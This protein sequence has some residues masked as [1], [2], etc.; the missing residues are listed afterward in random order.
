MIMGCEGVSAAMLLQYNHHN[1]KAT[2]IM[3]HWPTHPN[4]PI[5]AMLV[6]I[7]LLSLVITKRF[8]LLLMFHI[9]KHLIHV[10]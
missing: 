8:S 1:I 5:K 6:T 10:S 3:K 7:Y 4:N 9:Y 2:D